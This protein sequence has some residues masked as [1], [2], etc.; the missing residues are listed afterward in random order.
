MTRQSI[1]Y[2]SLAEA[3]KE[4]P[5]V[6]WT[7]PGL[8]EV[9]LHLRA[10]PGADDY[11]VVLCRGTLNDEIVNVSVPFKRL[12]IKHT[13]ASIVEYA[14][15]DSVYASGLGILENMRIEG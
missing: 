6:Y 13:R 14:K 3:A 9:H 7:A 8:K 2:E 4:E 1:D 5:R 11:D 12:P 15:D 10:S